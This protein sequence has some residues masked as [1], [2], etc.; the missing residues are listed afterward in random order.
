[1]SSLYEQLGG[2]EA[3]DAAVDIFYQKVLADDR[4]NHFFEGVD[5][6]NQRGMQKSFLAYAFGGPVKYSGK[7]MRAAHQHLDLND[8]HFDAV[9]EHLGATLKELNV[10]DE[11]IAKVAAIAEATRNDVLNRQPDPT[12]AG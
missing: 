1:M 12:P 11:L 5:L 6:D 3:I 8:T 10:A 4:I 2:K 9:V 7:Y